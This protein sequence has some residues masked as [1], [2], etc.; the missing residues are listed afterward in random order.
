M[1]ISEKIYNNIN[2]FDIFPSHKPIFDSIL[3]N[4]DKNKRIVLRGVLLSGKS[5]F[6][7]K[8]MMKIKERLNLSDKEAIIIDLPFQILNEMNKQE[9]KQISINFINNFLDKNDLNDL[10]KIKNYKVMILDDINDI[11]FRDLPKF[12]YE[13]NDNQI[14]IQVLENKLYQNNKNPLQKLG[15]KIYELV[16]PNEIDLKKMI[17]RY[18]NTFSS[19]VSSIDINFNKFKSKIT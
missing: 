12:K 6:C 1:I 18:N 17:E 7:Q 13:L 8:L 14:L 19:K 4:I 16:P 15:Y 3:N 10:I 11:L 9:L 5:F 2:N